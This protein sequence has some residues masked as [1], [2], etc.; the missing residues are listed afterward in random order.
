MQVRCVMTTA[1][2]L[3]AAATPRPWSVDEFGI[4]TE[5]GIIGDAHTDAD[6]A[7][8]VVA[9]NE[10]EALLDIADAVSESASRPVLRDA[11][12]RLAALRDAS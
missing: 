7:L 3:L 5:A 9:V 4:Y 6:T 12:A 1:R 11:F 2:D 10:Y 8:I